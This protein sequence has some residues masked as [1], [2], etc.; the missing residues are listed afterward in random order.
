MPASNP[1]KGWDVGMRHPA[2][3]HADCDLG[4]EYALWV[5]GIG[6]IEAWRARGAVLSA[7]LPPLPSFASALGFGAGDILAIRRPQFVNL[8]SKPFS[9]TL[10]AE[11][12]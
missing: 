6:E 9:G 4:E 12:A 3:L 7:M 1:R 2:D 5:A 11:A 10:F 8:L